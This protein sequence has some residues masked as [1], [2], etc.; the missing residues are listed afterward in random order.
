MRQILKPFTQV[1]LPNNYY[2]HKNILITGGGSGLGKQMAVHFAKLGASVSIIGRNHEKLEQVRNL[3]STEAPEAPDVH[4][5]SIDVREN[6]Q[7]ANL[8]DDML[9]NNTLPDVVINN[10]AGNFV[11]PTQKLSYNGWN[12][13]IDIVLKGTMNLSLEFGKRHIE[14]QKSATFLN[15]S[16]TY[17]ETGSAF[18][19]PSAV[20]KAACNNLTKSLAAEWG[21]YGLRF[22][23]VAPGPIYTDGAF[24][25][26][27][28]TGKFTKVAENNLP[29]GR[30]GDKAEIANLMTYLASDHNNWMTGQVINFDGGEVVG[31]SGE[32]NLLH[33]LTDEQWSMI[34]PSSKK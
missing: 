16:T 15:V 20:A 2:L 27:D 30:L 12:S 7:I 17:A 28:P 21:K 24:S 22:L 19:V 34:L 29:L 9:M 1:I 26:L 13:V 4:T 3:I 14:S 25:R 11:C 8:A 23:S 10:A 5:Y 18:V 31:N 6:Y 33:Q 32:F